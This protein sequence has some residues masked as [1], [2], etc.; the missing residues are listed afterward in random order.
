VAPAGAAYVGDSPADIQAAHAA[1]VTGIA[2]TWGVFDTAALCAEKPEIL[3][4]T[5]SELSVA[6]GV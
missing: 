5:M 3:V 2:V 1:G 6:L 4:H